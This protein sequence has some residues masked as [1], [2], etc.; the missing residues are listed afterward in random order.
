MTNRVLRL[1]SDSYIVPAPYRNRGFN[2]RQYR[3]AAALVSG[4]SNKQIARQLGTSEA[5]VKYHLTSIYRLAGVRRRADFIDF[6]SEIDG[7]LQN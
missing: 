7:N 5:T 2:R 1:V 4:A 3:V 6:A